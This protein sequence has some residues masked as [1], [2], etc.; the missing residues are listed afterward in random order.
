MPEPGGGLHE[1][2]DGQV[3]RDGRITVMDEIARRR[4]Q[5]D[6][7]G[8]DDEVAQLD[9]VL[10]DAARADPHEGRSLGHGQDLGHHDLHVVGPDPGRDDGEAAT[11]VG[12]GH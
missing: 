12:A 1:C 3:V 9:A 11:T 5:T 8:G 6:R 2:G 7:T 4:L 10:E